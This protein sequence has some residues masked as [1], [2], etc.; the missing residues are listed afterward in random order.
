M[1]KSHIFD[2]K[3]T[4]TEKQITQESAE[5]DGYFG[6]KQR[7]KSQSSEHDSKIHDRHEKNSTFGGKVTLE[8]MINTKIKRSHSNYH[9]HSINLKTISSIIRDYKFEGP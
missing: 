9:K 3:Y 5:D 4:S 6:S 2:Q 1:I 8:D 7:M